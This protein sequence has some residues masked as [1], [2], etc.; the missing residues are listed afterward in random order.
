MPCFIAKASV[1]NI[2]CVG[3]VSK[4]CGGLFFDRASKDDRSNLVNLTKERMRL[5]AAGKYPS[6]IIFP[7]GGTTNGNELI[8]F[9]KGAFISG[10]SV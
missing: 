2:P 5:C 4:A 8:K 7:E 6:L 3:T 1:L 10:E 9:A